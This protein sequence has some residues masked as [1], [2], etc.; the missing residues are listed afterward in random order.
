M[1]KFN[2]AVIGLGRIGLEYGLEKGRTQPASHIAAIMNNVNLRLVAV[3]DTNSERRDL[4][5]K[6]MEQ[7]S[8]FLK[9]TRN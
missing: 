7:R 3:C 4:F 5:Q 9:N 6:N 1:K 8:I 2:A